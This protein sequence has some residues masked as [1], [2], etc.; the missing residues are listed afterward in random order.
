MFWLNLA[1]INTRGY[2]KNLGK[3][4][5][6]IPRDYIVK[7]VLW[8]EYLSITYL[9]SLVYFVESPG[10]LWEPGG[11]KQRDGIKKGGFPLISNVT[12]PK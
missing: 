5:H 12:L 3:E 9:A 11:L 6:N 2:A 8:Y 10:W 4:N 1:I 7:K